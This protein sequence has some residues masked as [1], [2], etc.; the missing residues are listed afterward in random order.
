[1]E[2]E[3][4][5]SCK[6]ASKDAALKRGI[7]KEM[8]RKQ[9]PDYSTVAFVYGYAVHGVVPVLP[10]TRTALAASQALLMNGSVDTR[11]MVSFVESKGT[12]EGIY[13]NIYQRRDRLWLKYDK[14]IRKWTAR[15]SLD[16]PV[17]SLVADILAHTDLAIQE[18][19]TMQ[20]DNLKKIIA[21][22]LLATLDR[23][24]DLISEARYLAAAGQAEGTAL[25]ATTAAALL[26]FISGHPTPDM[27]AMQKEILAQLQQ[28]TAFLENTAK[29]IHDMV[30]GIAGDVATSLVP[31]IQ[32]GASYDD[33]SSHIINTVGAGA[34][35][36]FYLDTA[37]HAAFALAILAAV[38][39]S[40]QLVDFVT[41]GDEKVC[42]SCEIAEAGN[43]WK[44]DEVPSIPNH[45]GCRCWYS[46]AQ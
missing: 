35:A 23:Y 32:A 10:R 26:A 17:D 24:A 6:N 8:D 21:D 43:P 3:T 41:V 4:Y 29:I 28:S 16:V 18:A 12:I 45:G 2:T 14:R 13:S 36:A 38:T 37:I 7:S 20:R 27:D 15:L 9:T 33:V 5:V 40:G 30:D 34:G 19:T 11:L 44:P 31:K 39:D 25:G 42:I 46:P 1:M 22:A